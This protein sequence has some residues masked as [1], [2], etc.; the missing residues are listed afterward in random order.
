[1]KKR[2]KLSLHRETLRNLD[3]LDLLQA[4]G[5]ALAALAANPSYNSG[6]SWCWCSNPCTIPTTESQK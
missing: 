2:Q 5:G 4:A 3:A 6:D 1:M